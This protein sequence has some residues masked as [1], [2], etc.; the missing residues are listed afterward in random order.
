MHIFVISLKESLERR[1]HIKELLN[2]EGV[3]FAFFDAE[4]I[5]QNLD[6]EI[7]KLYSKRR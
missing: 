2:S 1:K 5:T 4:D 3:P 7:F 6:H